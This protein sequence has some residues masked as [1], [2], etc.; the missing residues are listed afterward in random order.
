MQ[1]AFIPQQPTPVYQQQVYPQQQQQIIPQQQQYPQFQEPEF[2][3]NDEST[4]ALTQAFSF[5]TKAF[6]GRYSTPTTNN[7]RISSNTRNKQ[8][9][10]PNLNM[11]NAGQM[12]GVMGNQQG[13]AQGYQ[14]GNQMNQFAG[15][16]YAGNQMGQ[17]VGNQW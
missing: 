8:I 10:Q 7:Q 12:V 11:G 4:A 6:Q 3:E 5:L 17:F 2:S 15:N 1:Q 9:A 16:Q 14:M 13:Y